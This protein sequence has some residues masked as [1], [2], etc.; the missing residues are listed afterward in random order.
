MKKHLESEME[1]L[2]Q[3]HEAEIGQLKD[4]LRKEKHSASTAVTDQVTQ[5]ERDLEEQWKRK[6][7]RL[8][9]QAEDRWK[10]KYGDLQEEYKLL[11]TQLAESTVKV[12]TG[13]V[14][15]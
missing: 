14:K 1:D 4:R 10:R 2:K 12:C 9:S 7:E 15:N 13:I 3:N 11:E 8:V 6:S 5:L